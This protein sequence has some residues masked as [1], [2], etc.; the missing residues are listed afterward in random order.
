MLKV[1]KVKLAKLAAM[2]DPARNSNENERR[3]AAGKLATAQAQHAAQPPRKNTRFTAAEF[4][5]RA[6]AEAAAV[7]LTVGE[8]IRR[9]V[10]RVAPLPKTAAEHDA[11]KAKVTAQRRAARA[12][13][14]RATP[15]IEI[16]LDL[17]LDGLFELDL[18]D[19]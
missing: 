18:S 12:A 15:K 5:A 10:E 11:R 7:G 8:W 19:D 3:V 2:A 14:K 6:R 13:A 9:E 4:T 16:K 17:D 1:T